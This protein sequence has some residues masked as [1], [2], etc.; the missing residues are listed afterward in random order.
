[1]TYPISVRR[2]VLAVKARGGL[3]FSETA[4]RFSVGIA[5]LVR[6]S[7]K[8]KIKPYER[9][10]GLKIDLEA[11]AQDVCDHPDAYQYERAARFGV[12]PK[13]ITACLP[14]KD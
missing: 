9:Q 5:S 14:R 11:L 13:A 3:I 4:E 6:W 1:M 2:H 12:T 8:I 7:S 10:K